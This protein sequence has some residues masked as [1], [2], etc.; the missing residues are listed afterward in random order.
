MVKTNTGMDDMV[1]RFE[2]QAIKRMREE[3]EEQRAEVAALARDLRDREEEVIARIEAGVPVDG[4]AVVMTRRRQNI[5]W[6]TV[7]RREL[8]DEAVVQAKNEWPVVFY[9]QLQID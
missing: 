1:S 3:L 4:Q 8:G 5:S 7:L 9:R 2:L 6:L